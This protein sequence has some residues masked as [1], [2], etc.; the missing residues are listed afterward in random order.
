MGLKDLR[1]NL[2]SLKFGKDR[3]GGGDSGLPYIKTS[4]DNEGNLTLLNSNKGGDEFGLKSALSDGFGLFNN[5]SGKI[6]INP[7]AYTEDFPLRGGL[8]A[9]VNSILDT[10]RIGK[11]LLDAPRG[12]LF[13]AKQVGLQL[14][15]PKIQ[16]GKQL[17]IENTRIYN[18][19]L[20]TIAQVGLSAF[21]SHF[22]RAGLYPKMSDTQKYYKIVTPDQSTDENRLG[23]LYRYKIA[24][25]KPPLSPT[26]LLGETL[27]K[28]GISTDENQLFDY[29]GGPGSFLGIGRTTINALPL[30]DRVANI[31]SKIIDQITNYKS[32]GQAG[33]YLTFTYKN[34][35]SRSNN[36][37]GTVGED[38]RGIISTDLLPVTSTSFYMPTRVG[39]GNPGRLGRPRVDYMVQDVNTRDQINMVPLFTSAI[40]EFGGAQSN[41]TIDGKK[42]NTRDLVKFRFES[43]DNA[44]PLLSTKIIFRA[45]LNSIQDNFSGDWDPV[46][47]TGRGENFYV[48]KGFNRTLSFNFKM[49]AQTREEM[50][51]LYQKMNFLASNTAPNH[52]PFMRGPIMTLT[53]GDYIYN[54][55]GILNSLNITIPDD[56]P[57]EIAMQDPE[58]KE[59][60]AYELPHIL[61]ASVQFTPIHNFFVQK[62]PRL[63]YITP[64][65]ERTLKDE[66]GKETRSIPGFLPVVNAGIVTPQA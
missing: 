59:K 56:S 46:R 23:N 24:S 30:R 8:F 14:M 13:L 40:N 53:I 34:F 41:V 64:N 2:K 38:F 65:T 62:D 47:Y 36:L 11:F 15:N 12:P 39:I 60:D 58:N 37:T 48:Y 5:P 16:T 35:Y 27:K 22:D 50:Q 1:T 32:N 4:F 52:S 21:G 20:N 44:N 63:W 18:V 26:N 17:G 49:A 29:N 61:E 42:Y 31:D 6:E 28:L 57:W 25:L 45:F 43:V 3:P 54:Q 7:A 55:P 9:P 10:I 51:P 33:K 19:G 66:N